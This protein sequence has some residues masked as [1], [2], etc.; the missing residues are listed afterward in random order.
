MRQVATLGLKDRSFL[1]RGGVGKKKRGGGSSLVL[2]SRFIS[3]N[4][5]LYEQFTK[6]ASGLSSSTLG[7]TKTQSSSVLSICGFS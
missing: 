6:G 7:L 3:H 4:M 2:L 5:S 1:C